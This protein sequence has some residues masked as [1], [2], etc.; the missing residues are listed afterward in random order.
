MHAAKHQISQHNTTTTLHHIT[1]HDTT[2]HHTTPHNTTHTYT[3]CP[4]PHRHAK[5][6]HW[7]EHDC[8][9]GFVRGS[10]FSVR[11]QRATSQ[12]N[13]KRIRGKIISV[14]KT[15]REESV[16][17]SQHEHISRVSF[18]V[19]LSAFAC[20]PVHSNSPI[21]ITDSLACIAGALTKQLSDFAFV[22][23]CVARVPDIVTEYMRIPQW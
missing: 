23:T 3:K 18:L 14:R 7:L 13:T 5:P 20:T 12:W 17:F 8:V 15:V 9:D 10:G 2:H 4:Q 21:T 1:S 16:V 11:E 22:K 19:C 6:R